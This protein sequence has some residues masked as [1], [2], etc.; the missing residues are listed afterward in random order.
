MRNLAC[1]GLTTFLS[2]VCLGHGADARV[3]PGPNVRVAVDGRRE[4]GVGLYSDGRNWRL[5]LH[6]ID[7]TQVILVDVTSRTRDKW[8]LSV[9]DQAVVLD[10]PRFVA[11]HAYR[12]QLWRGAT[13]VDKALVYLY[14]SRAGKRH[15][16]F[17]VEDE[18]TA[19]DEIRVVPKSAL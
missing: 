9:V 15:V 17:E 7:A 4:A 1:L 6:D 11:G 8:V 14:P 5:S 2:I 3:L 18:D 16:E 12:V 19:G 13:L 10:G